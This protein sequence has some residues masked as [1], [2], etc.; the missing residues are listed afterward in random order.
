MAEVQ[1]LLFSNGGYT[2]FITLMSGS[3]METQSIAT[4]MAM[5]MA[6]FLVS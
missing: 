1:I 6:Y 2:D 4:L 5:R 3:W